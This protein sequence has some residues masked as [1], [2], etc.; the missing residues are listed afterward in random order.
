M[1]KSIVFVLSLLT[2]TIAP[3]ILGHDVAFAETPMSQKSLV[4]LNQCVLPGFKIA[5]LQPLELGETSGKVK[6]LQLGGAQKVETRC[7]FGPG[8]GDRT[9][10]PFIIKLNKP[11][12]PSPF[13]IELRYNPEENHIKLPIF[14]ISF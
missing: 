11:V 5:P 6:D 14:N 10:G 13:Q 9:Q 1:K 3:S 12:A 4:E 2:S 8:G 7:F